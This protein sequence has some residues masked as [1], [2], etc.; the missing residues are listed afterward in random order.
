MILAKLFSISKRW[1]S[2]RLEAGGKCANTRGGKAREPLTE[3]MEELNLNDGRVWV[4]WVQMKEK[5]KKGKE[6][7][8]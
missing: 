6:G 7:K 4:I 3:A 2:A 8:G 1:Y 5:K